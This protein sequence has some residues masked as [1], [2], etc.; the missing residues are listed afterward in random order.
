MIIIHI[1]IWELGEDIT[2]NKRVTGSFLIHLLVNHRK[3]SFYLLIT[4]AVLIF[5]RQNG[6]TI[7]RVVIHC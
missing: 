7:L 4:I 6:T 1:P 2:N 5:K 3:I